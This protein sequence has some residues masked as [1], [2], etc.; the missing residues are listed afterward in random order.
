MAPL[1][2]AADGTGPEGLPVCFLPS[3]PP[4]PNE[5]WRLRRRVL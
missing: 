3:S 4:C 1:A 2:L 5:K